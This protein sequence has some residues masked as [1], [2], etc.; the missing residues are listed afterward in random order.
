[1]PSPW[2][3][4]AIVV[5]PTKV[6]A[7]GN[8]AEV[9]TLFE[10]HGLPAPRWYE[11]TQDDPGE[12]MAKQAVADG[13]DLVVAQGGDG[14][15]RA[16]AAVLCEL[17][18]V[19]GLL[20]AGTGNLLARNL[21]VP[22]DLGP[23]VELL[24]AGPHRAIDVL[25]LDGTAYVVMAGTGLDALM[26][27]ETS[28]DLKDLAGWAAYAVAGARAVRR[29]RAHRVRLEA[30]GARHSMRAVGVVVGNVGTLTGGLELLPDADASDG[31]MHVAVLTARTVRDW[32]RLGT[33]VLRG[34]RPEATSMRVLRARDLRV[35]WPRP[36]PAE[37]DG[38]LVDDRR[39][40]R[41]GVR[42]S[43]LEVCAPE[44]DGS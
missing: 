44:P 26:F 5:N 14:T 3:S 32:L 41:F 40:V 29:A 35:T 21:D 12:G 11:T 27:E 2:S 13:A 8:R 36:L 18:A 23:A 24:A 7:G 34:S 31:R 15:V 1:M 16:C 28:D 4:V 19:L 10:R 42:P 20:P 22:L 43:C 25:E 38:D 30:D 37:V 33:S 17:D 6:D 9:E 39:S